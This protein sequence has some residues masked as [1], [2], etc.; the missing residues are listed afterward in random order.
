MQKQH[1]TSSSNNV[2]LIIDMQNDFILPDSPLYVKRAES[3][4]PAIK[5]FLDFGRKS[6]WKLIYICRSHDLSGIDAEKY[7]LHLFHDN[8]G[9]CIRGT[10]GFEIPDIIS[11][12]D[13]DLLIFKQRFSAFFCTNLDMI[14][15]RLNTKKIYITGT[16]YP[17][18]IRATAVDAISRD[19]ETIVV[20]DCCSAQTKEIEDNN[21]ED[22]RNMGIK[23]LL[24]KDICIQRQLY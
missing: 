8:N 3:T 22:M 10:K 20:T 7:R 19:Y 12:Q 2:I 15:K 5:S 23:C 17:N 21:I 14:L 16:Q 13:E 1:I 9:I 6:D 11:P 18:C 4:L 24:S